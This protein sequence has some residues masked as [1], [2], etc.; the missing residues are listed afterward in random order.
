MN[1]PELL[2]LKASIDFNSS[3]MALLVRLTSEETKMHP[4]QIMHW[5]EASEAQYKKAVDVAVEQIMKGKENDTVEK[6]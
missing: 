6:S 3:I 1:M 4:K 5:I 2:L